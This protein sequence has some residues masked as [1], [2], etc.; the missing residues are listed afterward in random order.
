MKLIIFYLSRQKENHS[1]IKTSKICD[2]FDYKTVGLLSV[3][4][5]RNKGWKIQNI[6]YYLVSSFFRFCKGLELSNKIAIIAVIIG[7]ILF[8]LDKTYFLK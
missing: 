3:L 6:E 1:E 2:L 8:F 7:I 5:Y 4:Y